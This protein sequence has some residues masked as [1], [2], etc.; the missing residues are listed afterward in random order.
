MRA[1]LLSLLLIFQVGAV[2]AAA[3]RVVALG[4]SLTSGY[5][6]EAGQDFPSQLAK[7]LAGR[8]LKVAMENAGVAGD[9]SA[10]GL[11]RVDWSVGGELKPALVIVGLGGNDMLRGIDP[12]HTKANLAGILAKLNE[13][14]IPVLLLGMRTGPNMGAEYRQQF[15]AIYPALAEEYRVSLYP[16]F[17]EGVALNPAMNQRDGIH[18]NQLGVARMVEGVLPYALQILEAR[19]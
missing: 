4:D 13:K 12:A 15:D 8:G 10:G 5:G 11:A 9:T 16:F 6:L 18:P 19:P 2:Q 17:L 7:A 14:Q 3:L 1:I